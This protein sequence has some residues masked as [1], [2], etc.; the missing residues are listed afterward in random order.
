MGLV[1]WL[2][3]GSGKLYQFEPEFAPLHSV[4]ARHELEARAPSPV[5]RVDLLLEGGE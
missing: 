2:D 3:T 4:D 1:V 5:S